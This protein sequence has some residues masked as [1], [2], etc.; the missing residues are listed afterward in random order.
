MAE[1]TTKTSTNSKGRQMIRSMAMFLMCSTLCYSQQSNTLS[2]ELTDSAR[3]IFEIENRVSVLFAKSFPE[4]GEA[5]EGVHSELYF[6]PIKILGWA[7]EQDSTNTEAYYLKALAISKKA[8]EGEGTW[9]SGL[10][11]EARALLQRSTK[12][13]PLN[14]ESMALL[15][16]IARILDE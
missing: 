15:D 6:D 3:K 8:Y 14:K 16:E 1:E 11:R 7:I 4:S 10:I 13:K 9:N 2:R 5:G 12:V